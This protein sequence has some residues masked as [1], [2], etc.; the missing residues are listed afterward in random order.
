MCIHA[1]AAEGGVRRRLRVGC[2]PDAKGARVGAGGRGVAVS[3]AP[4]AAA[5]AAAVAS[6]SL[7][8]CPQLAA[9]AQCFGFGACAAW[10][11]MHV[12]TPA[13][14]LVTALYGA[15]GRVLPTALLRFLFDTAS[16]GVTTAPIEAGCC[17]H[18]DFR[19]FSLL[20]V[21][22]SS[23]CYHCTGIAA[24]RWVDVTSVCTLVGAHGAFLVEMSA[25]AERSATFVGAHEYESLRATLGDDVFGL[26]PAT[27]LLV[28]IYMFCIA[29]YALN[30]ASM[31]SD[32]AL[33]GLGW[34]AVAIVVAVKARLGQPIAGLGLLLTAMGAGSFRSSLSAMHRD[35][36][37]G[38][39][40]KSWD[41]VLY[42]MG[43]HIFESA[44]IVCLYANEAH[45]NM[46]LGS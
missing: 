1:D 39:T 33:H 38:A 37:R 12:G 31:L 3:A 30:L 17:G 46:H 19:L 26:P 5:P 24:L 45:L 25:A 36:A 21:M 22:V 44:A 23:M 28:A 2:A 6:K 8:T 13:H 7:R 4:A 29:I 9:S 40:C 15:C 16:E 18:A 32:R 43:L 10:A 11:S 35:A 27:A 34:P 42:H 20:L 14:A 41:E